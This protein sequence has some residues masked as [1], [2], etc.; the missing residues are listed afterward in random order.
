MGL[1]TE[2]WRMDI[3][4]IIAALAAAFYLFARHIYTYWDRKNFKTLPNVSY[5][6]G[7]FNKVFLQKQSFA[8]FLIDTYNQTTEPFVGIY[9]SFCPILFIRDPELIRSILVKD[10]NNFMNRGA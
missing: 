6:M 1:I 7:H 5:F 9:S 2:D 4:Y 10:F 3:F 8:N